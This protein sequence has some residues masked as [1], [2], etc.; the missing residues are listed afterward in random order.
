MDLSF[1][2][3]DWD[4]DLDLD[5]GLADAILETLGDLATVTAPRD[6]AT[7]YVP[8]TADSDTPLAEPAAQEPALDEPLPSIM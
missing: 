4:A 5:P 7:A 3:M 1:D 6:S 8:L 2:A